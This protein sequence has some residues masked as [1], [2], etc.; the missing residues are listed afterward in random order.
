MSKAKR[1]KK[2]EDESSKVISALTT[3]ATE[4]ENNFLQF[5]NHLLIL[6]LEVP[7]ENLAVVPEIS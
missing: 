1:W 2:T 3:K 5:P 6:L 7:M 4:L